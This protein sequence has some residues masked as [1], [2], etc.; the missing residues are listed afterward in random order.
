[1]KT[2]IYCYTADMN[3]FTKP[4][5]KKLIPTVK[6]A[7]APT[8]M[9]TL[10][11]FMTYY[12][13]GSE[14]TMIGPFA[15]LSF[16]R[17]RTMRN[18][19]ECMIKNFAIFLA[20]AVLAFLAVMNLPLC[21]LINVLGLFWIAY[22]LIDEYN[23]NN[24]FPAGMAL[25]FF[26]IAPAHTLPALGNRIA[27]LLATFVLV[28]VF[29]FVLT[30]IKGKQNPLPGYLR[31]GFG[32]CENQ[33]NL[34]KAYTSQTIP[35]GNADIISEEH[36]V[37]ADRLHNALCDINKK[38]SAEIYAYNRASIFP[39]GKTNWYCRFILFFQIFNF[40]TMDS[41]NRENLSLA[42]KLYQDFLYQF[43][44]VTPTADYHRLNF[45]L[46]KPDIRSFRLRFA[47]RQVITLTPC[48]AFAWSSS[49]PNAYWL[50]ISVFFM[51]IPFTDHTRQRIRQRVGGTIAGIV[52]C[53]VLFSLFDGF[54]AR[55]AIMTIAN[56]MIYGANGYGPTV[57]Y[58]TCSALAISTL[59]A[60]I[61]LILGLRLLYTLAG[62]AIALAANKWIF[63]IRLG[64]Q[65]DYLA[66]MIRSI[67]REL[68]DYDPSV[69]Y[70]DGYQRWE[71]DQKIIKTYLLSKRLE[72]MCEALPEGECRFDYK[73]FEKKHITIM[74][75]I[76]ARHF[77]AYRNQ[78]SDL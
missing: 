34:C 74:A 50:V 26:Q 41:D 10:I 24:Y 9:A 63:P 35:A 54:Y 64:K 33:L 75:Q 12:L 1:M 2:H 30:R 77:T 55:V 20:M 62:A 42:E 23:P 11:F 6:G 61:S 37:K 47:L 59:E 48:L 72:G 15:T 71:I 39:K 66:E 4:D 32:I 70:G 27:A 21:I 65:I 25:I 17:Y 31:E 8:I 57:A 67:R 58:I 22:I 68:V 40:L 7:I 28:F 43:E 19:Y 44:N 53:L 36:T 51:M 14:N 29:T 52:I 76:L 69:S 45:R 49:L 46:K 13:F 18:H 16:L 3:K 38:A 5:Y 73:K 56:F 78:S 60:N